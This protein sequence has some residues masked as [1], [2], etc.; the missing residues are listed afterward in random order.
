M[1]HLKNALDDICFDNRAAVYRLNSEHQR[2]CQELANEQ[3]LEE[4]IK[5]QLRKSE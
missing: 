1:L 2:I 3:E 5:E 4:K